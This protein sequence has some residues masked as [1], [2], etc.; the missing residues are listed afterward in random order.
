MDSELRLQTLAETLPFHKFGS[1]VEDYFQLTFQVPSFVQQEI[2]PLSR[3]REMALEEEGVIQLTCG[4]YKFPCDDV[5]AEKPQLFTV[6]SKY[7]H[8]ATCVKS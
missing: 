4:E 2:L 5:F 7:A 3:E 8:V 1:G 6:A